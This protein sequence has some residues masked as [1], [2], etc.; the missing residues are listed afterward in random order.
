MS[1]SSLLVALAALFGNDPVTA[2]PVLHHGKIW[3]ANRARP[4]AEAVEAYTLTSAYAAGQDKDK[5]FIEPGKLADFVVLSR[6]I[7]AP[8]ERDR[9]ADTRVVMTIVGGKVV[10]EGHSP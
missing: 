8:T 9:I 2:D 6:D 3:T 4:E 5:G 7:L 10:H 1:A